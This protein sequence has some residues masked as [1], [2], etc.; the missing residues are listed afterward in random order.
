MNFRFKPW[1]QEPVTEKDKVKKHIGEVMELLRGAD[2]VIVVGPDSSWEEFAS[3]QKAKWE[4]AEAKIVCGGSGSG[5][6]RY[7]FEGY[8][9]GLRPMKTEPEVMLQV[10][11]ET[12]KKE[13]GRGLEDWERENVLRCLQYAHEKYAGIVKE[14]EIHKWWR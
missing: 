13:R 3:D 8:L 1:G 2:E 7:A 4:S 5:K 14:M 9:A 11:E 12:V 10:I 6:H